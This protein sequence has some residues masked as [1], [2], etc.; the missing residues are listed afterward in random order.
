MQWLWLEIRKAYKSQ[1][2]K[3]RLNQLKM[4]MIDGTPFPKLKAKAS[5]TKHLL[6][7]VAAVLQQILPDHPV[8]ELHEM[9]ILVTLSSKLDEILDESAGPVLAPAAARDLKAGLFGYN[10]RLTTLC[11]RLHGQGAMYF[12]Y[13][14]KHHY[15]LHIALLAERASPK[16]WW[17]YQG[18][19]FMQK[20]KLLCQARQ[21]GVANENLMEKV[22]IKYLWALDMLLG[23]VG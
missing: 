8:P 18:E 16:I 19:D 14:V 1:K 2:S 9:F 4:K 17:C 15:M 6:K 7:P 23:H 12:N 3:C 13:T 10:Q 22:A 20:V 21:R 5:E 11:W